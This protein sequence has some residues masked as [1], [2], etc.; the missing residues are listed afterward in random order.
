MNRKHVILANLM[1]ATL[2]VASFAQTDS[3]SSQTLSSAN[4]TSITAPPAL[5]DGSAPAAIQPTTSTPHHTAPVSFRRDGLWFSNSDG[6]TH[7]Q[8]HGYAQADN[9]LFWS[10]TRGQDLDTFL[11]RRI[12]P[13]IEGTLFNQVDFRFMP[14]FGA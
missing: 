9:R 2:T 3:A 14:D 13:V 8:V 4:Q 6:S 11:F 5:S 10:N 1:F 7:L 12:R